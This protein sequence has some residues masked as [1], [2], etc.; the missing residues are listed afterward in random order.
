MSTEDLRYEYKGKYITIQTETTQNPIQLMGQEA[1]ECWQANTNDADK[2]YKRG[3]ECVKSGHGRVLEFPQ[4]YILVEGYSARFVREYYVHLGGAPTRLQASTRYID[5][6]KDGFSY[7]IPPSIEKDKEAR[8]QY[9]SAMLNINRQIR[10]LI[11]VYKVPKEDA[12]M[13]LPLGMTST[14]VCRTNARNIIDMSRQRCCMRAYHEYRDFMEH[15][16]LA[17]SEYSQEWKELLEAQYGAKCEF[18]RYCPESNGCGR[19]PHLF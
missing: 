14:F 2:N 10:S 9:I 17:L 1:G 15:L 5:Y 18:L 16:K 13:L 4:I 6:T 3:L 8:L 11:D 7:V 19:Y 12:A